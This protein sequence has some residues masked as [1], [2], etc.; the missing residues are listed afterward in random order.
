MM[1]REDLEVIR[2]IR[3]YKRKYYTNLLLRGLIWTLACLL[4]VFLVLASAEYL[5]N[6]SSTVRTVLFFVC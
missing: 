5:A 2:N 4:A 3:R 1:H 6:F